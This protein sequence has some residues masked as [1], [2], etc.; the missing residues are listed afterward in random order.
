MINLWLRKRKNDIIV[1]RGADIYECCERL[2]ELQDKEYQQFHSKLVP[3][4]PSETI[5]GVR[6]P[7]LKKLAKELL[8]I[9]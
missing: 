5:I 6:I 8:T 7:L 3:N 9:R 4:I 2:Y 1:H